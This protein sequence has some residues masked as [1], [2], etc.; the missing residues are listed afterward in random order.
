MTAVLTISDLTIHRGH[1]RVLEDLSLC[2]NK[3]EMV[4]LIGPNGSGKTTLLNSIA[5]LSKPSHGEIHIGGWP[6]ADQVEQARRSLG[7]MVAQERLP[8]VLSGRQ[9]LQLFA[10]ARGLDS[11]PGASLEQADALGFTP[12]LDEWVMN[13][14]LGTRQKLS[15]LMALVGTPPLILLDEP[16]NGLDPVS[17]R[18]LKQILLQLRSAFGCCTLMAIHDLGTVE[19][20]H[21][22]ILVLLDGRIVLDWNQQRMQEE[23][24][25][26]GHTLEDAVV[27]ALTS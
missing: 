23:L 24:H 3:G 11:I 1:K 12:W 27:D 20:L 10:Q 5:G 26:R 17:T 19:Q 2:L 16:F 8:D 4:A 25:Q 7:F 13:Y 14:S 21:D 15:V 6:L 18:A 9:C 22:H